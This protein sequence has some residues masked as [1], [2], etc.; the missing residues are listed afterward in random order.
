MNLVLSRSDQRT[1]DQLAME[2]FGLPAFTL[3]ENAGRAAATAI[4]RYYGPVVGQQIGIICGKGN[5]GGDGLVLARVLVALGAQVEIRLT[6]LPVSPESSRNLTLLRKMQSL[7]SGKRLRI[8]EWNRSSEQLPPADLYVDALLGTGL[9]SELR[10]SV[11]QIVKQ[12]NGA[13]TPVV[14]IDIPTGLDANLGLALG[15]AV[16][17]SLTVT[18]G[19]LKPGLLLNDGP[20]YAGMIEVADIGIPQELA[21]NES[22]K[23]RYWL[24]TKRGISNLLPQR[25]ARAHK[26]SAG[27]VLI[28]GG[29]AGLTGAPVMSA[30]AAARIGA[31]YVACATPASAQPAMTSKLT[32]IPAIGLP[33]H[34]DGGIDGET[35]HSVLKPWLSK[36]KCLLIGPGLGRHP[37]TQ[38]FARQ[39]LAS[40]DLPVVVDADGLRALAAED[41]ES[42]SQGRWI[43]TPHMGEFKP[44]VN[45]DVDSENPLALASQWAR[46]WDSTLILKGLPSVVGAPGCDTL[47]CGTGSNALA[48]AGTGDILAGLCAGLLAQGCPPFHAAACAVHIG[49]AAADAYTGRHPAVTMMATDMLDEIPAVLQEHSSLPDST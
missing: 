24:T 48:T 3:M 46:S 43:L 18:M 1:M 12:L 17:A 20:K 35:A 36:A 25:P 11:A 2:D 23:E 8:A 45:A 5:N 4:N 6:A 13:T 9:K 33:E 29:M 15:N 44:M 37:R 32:E 27:M 16:R 47:I 19:A 26:Y 14:A 7:Q 22:V 30:L 21:F 34:P 39:L 28:V 40:T 42:Q 41:I 31:G 10:G 38:A 49:G